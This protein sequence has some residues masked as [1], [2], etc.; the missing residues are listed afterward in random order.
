[1]S[2]IS[3]RRLLTS[4]VTGAALADLAWPLP[5]WKGTAVQKGRIHQS[6]ARWCYPKFRLRDLC[7][8]AA[9]M[10]LKGVDLLPPERWMVPRDF[11]L[12]CSM[13]Y[14][15]A[16]DIYNGL[17]RPENLPAIE[18]AFRRNLP[19][20]VRY[21]VPNVICFSGARKG[22]PD[23]QGA[24]YCIAALNRLK[25]IAEDHGVTICMELLNSK[26][27]HP[28]YMCDHVAWGVSVV[29]AVNSPHVKLLFDIYHMQIMEGDLIR[30]IQANREWI[31]HFHTGGVP[32]RHELDGH[33]EVRWDGVMRG[34]LA[35]GFQGFVAHEF[36]P[37]GPDPLASLRQAAVLCDV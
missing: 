27:D 37:A 8:T 28:D 34:I 22:M 31:A 25:R 33:Q 32:G 14:A 7:R 29:R 9:E 2:A 4:A 11:G 16:N 21:G 13:G 24:N 35:T 1:M 6:V 15:G 26:I 12:I 36:I 5:Q 18:T 17:N 19:L 10:G 3:R 20:A 23:D 30:T